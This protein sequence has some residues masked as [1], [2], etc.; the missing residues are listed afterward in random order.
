MGVGEEK[1]LKENFFGIL[2]EIGDV[3][4]NNEFAEK[5]ISEKEMDVAGISLYE[6]SNDTDDQ[7]I[8]DKVSLLTYQEL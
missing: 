5:K 1:T 7:P 4:G 2:H 8:R 6:K 3:K